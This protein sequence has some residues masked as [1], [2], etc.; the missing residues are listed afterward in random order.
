MNDHLAPSTPRPHARAECDARPKIVVIQ[1][2]VH[3][4]VFSSF[5]SRDARCGAAR[6]TPRTCT[7]KGCFQDQAV[8]AALSDMRCGM[9]NGP[10]TPHNSQPVASKFHRHDALLLP[11]IYFAHMRALKGLRQGLHG[12]ACCGAIAHCVCKMRA[13]IAAVLFCASF[14]AMQPLAPGCSP[15]TI[16]SARVR[17]KGRKRAMTA[18]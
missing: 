1:R 9:K 14:H 3:S 5:R 11:G 13:M 15:S 12:G 6:C 4:E 2:N 7:A 16:R 17:W 8:V 18:V 10:R